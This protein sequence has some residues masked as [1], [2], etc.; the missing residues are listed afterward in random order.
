MTAQGEQL[1]RD[2]VDAG[3]SK[4]NI[5]CI[6]GMLE[7]GECTVRDIV[8]VGGNALWLDVLRA[9]VEALTNDR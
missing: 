4:H 5:R 9:G 1:V 8:S 3:A 7:T 6:L 2:H